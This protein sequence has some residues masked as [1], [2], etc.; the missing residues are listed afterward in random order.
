M[1]QR[2]WLIIKIAFALLMIGAGVLH[3]IKPAVYLPIIP[4]FL[5]FAMPIIYISGVVEIVLGVLLLL[6]NKYAKI[7]ALGLLV[8]MILFLPIHVL[9]AFAEQPAIG[10]HTVAFIRIIV[11]FLIIALVW[12]LYKVLAKK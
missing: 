1:K 10:S 12:K 8:L 6:N 9:D 4:L 7:G 3:L 2:I 11:Q 5:P